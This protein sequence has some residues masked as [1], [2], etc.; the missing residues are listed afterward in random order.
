MEAPIEAIF[1]RNFSE[2]VEIIGIGVP[3]PT[4]YIGVFARID[5][6]YSFIPKLSPQ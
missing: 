5:A 1:G 3:Y 6:Y 4:Q 2:K